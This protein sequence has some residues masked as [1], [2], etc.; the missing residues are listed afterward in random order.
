MRVIAELIELHLR[1]TFRISKGETSGKKNCIVMFGDGLG[2]CCPSVYYGY[3]AED[4]HRVINE[5]GIEIPE[6]FE[7]SKTLDEFEDDIPF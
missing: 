2:E 6:P 1:E 7:F 5:D 4:C 3:S